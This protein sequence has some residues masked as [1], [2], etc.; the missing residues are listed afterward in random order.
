M[1]TDELSHQFDTQ[2]WKQKKG[3]VLDEYAKSLYLTKAQENIV[4]GLA[5]TYE[6]TDKI[7]EQ[8]EPLLVV[9]TITSFTTY[10]SFFT[11]T[12]PTDILTV[13]YEVL[14]DVTPTIPLDNNDIHMTLENPF[15][16]PDENISYRVTVGAEIARLYSAYV[17]V[18]YT[19]HYIKQPDPIVLEDLTATGLT[20]QGVA[21][22]TTSVLNDK[23]ALDIVDLAV[24][25]ALSD[26]ARFAQ[27]PQKE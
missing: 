8:L 11:I 25:L 7:R 22:P 16:K 10:T 26:V 24:I 18:S 1:T 6:Y 27:Q 2:V 21:T 19:L 20:I 23:L 9:N 5:D 12:W 14:N 13:T 3:L 15:R 17:P 4:I